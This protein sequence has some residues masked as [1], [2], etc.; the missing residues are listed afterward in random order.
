MAKFFWGLLK[1]IAFWTLTPILLIAIGAGLGWLG[2][3]FANRVLTLTSII[4]IA[5]GVIWLALIWLGITE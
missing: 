2:V 4:F 3:T 5:V 1:D